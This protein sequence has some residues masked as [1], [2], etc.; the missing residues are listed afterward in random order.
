M[1]DRFI[2]RW[3][4][5]HVPGA[6]HCPRAKGFDCAVHRPR[7]DPTGNRAERRAAKRARRHRG[8]R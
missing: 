2:K 7:P 5:R 3:V 1:G 4:V 6:C 8:D